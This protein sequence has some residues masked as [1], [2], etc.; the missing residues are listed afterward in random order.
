MD[1]T[2][3][4]APTRLNLVSIAGYFEIQTV[5]SSS[6]ATVLRRISILYKTKEH[7]INRSNTVIISSVREWLFCV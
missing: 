1:C 3:N 7:G 5:C 4:P 6:G 2:Q